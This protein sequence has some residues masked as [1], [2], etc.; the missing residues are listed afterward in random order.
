MRERGRLAVDGN[1]LPPHL[2]DAVAQPV[3]QVLLVRLLG[4]QRDLLVDEV[5][6][7]L[8]SFFLLGLYP[9]LL[10][11][12]QDV[13]LADVVHQ[14][15][16]EVSQVLDRDGPVEEALEI[17]GREELSQG[18]RVAFVDATDEG[19]VLGLGLA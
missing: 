13:D 16:G 2:G 7:I 8:I 11:M 9:F 18:V 12:E 3:L 15:V 17:G 6:A 1:Q 19:C 5:R 14:P 4:E 10:V